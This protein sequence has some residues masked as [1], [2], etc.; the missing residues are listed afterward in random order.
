MGVKF[1]VFRDKSSQ[2]DG[3][4]GLRAVVME[5]PKP[6]YPQSVD[7]GY[8]MPG[9]KSVEPDPENDGCVIIR[10]LGEIVEHLN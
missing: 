6:Y 9:L 3:I 10:A 4:K 8:I 1:N 2:S 7:L 5:N